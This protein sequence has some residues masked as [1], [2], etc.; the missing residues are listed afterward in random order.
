[1]AY[2]LD[3][4]VFIRARRDHYRFAVC[5]GFWEWLVRANDAARV[6]SIERIRDELARGNDRLVEWAT[7]LPPAFFQSPQ[8][9]TLAALP[10]VSGWVEA[11]PNYER[12]AIAEFLSCADYWLVAEALARGWIVV[13][14]EV[15]APGSRKR[16]KLPDVCAGMGVAHT[17]PFQMLEDEGARFVL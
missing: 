9:G 10:R 2:L 8:A 3:A 16:V 5:P 7:A 15:S 11:Q 6:F 12:Q 1:M 13:T 14:H 4:D 17:S